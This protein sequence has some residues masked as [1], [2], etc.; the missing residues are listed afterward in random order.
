MPSDGPDLTRELDEAGKI[1]MGRVDRNDKT[2]WGGRDPETGDVWNAGVGGE[3]FARSVVRARVSKPIVL[4]RR[5]VTYGPWEAAPDET[6]EE[7]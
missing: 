1:V 4:V 7:P 3:T 6:P 2:E 5:T